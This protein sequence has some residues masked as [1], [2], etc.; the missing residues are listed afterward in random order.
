MLKGGCSQ[1]SLWLGDVA[2]H[3]LCALPLLLSLPKRPDVI[4]FPGYVCEGRG[5]GDALS[6]E[7][8]SIGNGKKQSTQKSKTL[9]E[10]PKLTESQYASF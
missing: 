3:A 7:I 4:L 8:V 5:G 9:A 10:S 1:A 6:L 2:Q